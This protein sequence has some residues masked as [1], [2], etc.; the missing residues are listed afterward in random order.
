M[1]DRNKKINETQIEEMM[2][3][4]KFKLMKI[5]NYEEEIID[6]I[7]RKIFSKQEHQNLENSQ[8][9]VGNTN[10]KS[11]SIVERLK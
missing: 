10:D 3:L 1:I 7:N 11:P 4:S 2:E 9:S 6:E 5:L 8:D